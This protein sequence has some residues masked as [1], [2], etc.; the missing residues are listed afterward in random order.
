MRFKIEYIKD[1]KKAVMEVEA[2][3]LESAERFVKE[4]YPDVETQEFE[5]LPQEPETTLEEDFLDE[6]ELEDDALDD[7]L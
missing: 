4:R 2:N 7:E 6:L 1:G 3:S 5:G